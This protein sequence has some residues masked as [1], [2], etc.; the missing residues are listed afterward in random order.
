MKVNR[1]AAINENPILAQVQNED[2]PVGSGDMRLALNF[3]PGVCDMPVMPPHMFLASYLHRD[4]AEF[5]G[6]QHHA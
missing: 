2:W 6:R 4:L 3:H 1:F 5:L